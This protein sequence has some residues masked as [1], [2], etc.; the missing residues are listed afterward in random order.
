[1]FAGDANAC[2]HVGAQSRQRIITFTQHRRGF[3]QRLDKPQQHFAVEVFLALEVVIQIGFGHPGT[4]RD[5]AGL[6]G[7]EAVGGEFLAGSGEDQLLV[8]YADGTHGNKGWLDGMERFWRFR[9]RN[10]QNY[11][12]MKPAHLKGGA[13]LVRSLTGNGAG[14]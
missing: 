8:A 10:I 7:V 3:Q 6:G 12:A 14:T 11:I 9:F 5:I 2:G 13:M 1:M 4:R